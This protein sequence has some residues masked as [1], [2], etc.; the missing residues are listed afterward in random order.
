MNKKVIAIIVVILLLLIGGGVYM[1]KRGE[2]PTPTPTPEVE[3]PQEVPTE[4]P[5]EAVDISTFKVKV[6]NGTAVAGLAAK[7]KTALETAG[8]TVSS[9]GNADTKD[10][11]TVEIQAKSTVAASV[12]SKL[13]EEI[14]KSYSIGTEKSLADSSEDDIIVI[15]GT[16][17]QPTATPSAKSTTPAPTTSL[18]KT[19]TPTPPAGGSP[20]PTLTP[21]PT[22]SQ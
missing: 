2:E 19:P 17:S 11:Q 13:K 3:A 21:T 12:L 6:L 10:F 4:V 9:T 20:T 15:L 16:K 8:F 18:T 7:M 5:Q 22:K 1:A 14:G